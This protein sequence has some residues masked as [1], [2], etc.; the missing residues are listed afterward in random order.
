MK[1][2]V[3][4]LRIIL[5]MA[6]LAMLAACASSPSGGGNAAPLAGSAWR[7]VEIQSMD[8]QTYTPLSV[9]FYDLHFE[10]DGRVLVRAD[11]NRGQGSYSQQGSQLSFGNIAI[12][13]ALCRPQ[14]LDTRFLRELS[15]VRSFVVDAGNLY[16]ATMADGAILEFRP[17]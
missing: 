16:L 14:S 6:G 7:L 5:C 10:E 2:L 9:E 13:R 4:C 1:F 12:T 15:F 8:D 3:T 17:L 11:C